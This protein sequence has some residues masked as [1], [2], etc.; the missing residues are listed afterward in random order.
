MPKLRITPDS[1]FEKF[2]FSDTFLSVVDQ[3]YPPRELEN[4]YISQGSGMA[5]IRWTSS[6]GYLRKI[7][8]TDQ[9]HDADP[10]YMAR[11]KVSGLDISHDAWVR[12]IFLDGHIPYFIPE[13]VEELFLGEDWVVIGRSKGDHLTMGPE[14]ENFRGNDTFDLRGGNDSVW[15]GSGSDKIM[16]GRGHDTLSGGK[17]RDFISGGVGRDDLQGGAGKD[18]IKGGGGRD[19][20]IGGRGADQIEGGRANDVLTGGAGSDTFLFWGRS[21]NDQITDF[22]IDRD[23]I[24]L[25][26]SSIESI[27]GVPNGVVI[28]HTG[29][30]IHL[31]GVSIEDL[32]NQDWL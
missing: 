13:K 8:A 2:V 14:D 27:D 22:D 9:S 1:N 10:Y 20:I 25:I 16:G 23:K 7:E 12:S 19:I 4:G 15:A 24:E 17:G 18:E 29:G 31:F 6:R 3:V 21:G 26:E 28:S 32:S 11:F 30:E 5:G